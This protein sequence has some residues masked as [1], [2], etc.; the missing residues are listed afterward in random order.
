MYD[1]EVHEDEEN[2]FSCYLIPQW[3]TVHILITRNYH[4]HITN[5]VMSFSS[6][7]SS[8]R[9]ITRFFKQL[10]ETEQLCV[11]YDFLN[12]HKCMEP[13]SSTHSFSCC[14]STW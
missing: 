11:M 7:M 12:W 14:I 8:R 6:I 2:L 10:R 4:T 3:Q 1:A 13:L 9:L 5:P